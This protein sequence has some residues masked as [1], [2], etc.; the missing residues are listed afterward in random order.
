MSVTPVTPASTGCRSWPSR[1]FARAKSIGLDMGV[2]SL[3]E[4][5][6]ELVAMR[7]SLERAL[8]RP[9]E[10]PRLYEHK[11][12]ARLL[13]VAPKT[14]SRMVACGE[15]LPVRI[16]GKSLIPVEEIDRV[17]R[18][19]AKANAPEKAPR[20]D[21]DAFRAQVKRARRG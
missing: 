18:P 9:T 13:G 2:V 12:A 3:E 1:A 21:A 11:E 15:L 10:R 14:V 5:R 16:R 17:S 6:A 7:E 20:F 19:R 4:V 8:A